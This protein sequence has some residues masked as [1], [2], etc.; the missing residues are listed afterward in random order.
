MMPK[1]RA[2][3]EGTLYKRQ[4]GRSVASITLPRGKRKFFYGQ[5][6]KR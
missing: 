2:N 6:A 5:T 3:H 1:R 4:E